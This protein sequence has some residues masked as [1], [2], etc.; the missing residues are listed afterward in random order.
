[1]K[2]L[3]INI[4]SIKKYKY[5][6]LELE[7]CDGFDIP[8][9]FI[10]DIS[11]PSI[12]EKGDLED[13]YYDAYHCYD[14]FI[15]L[16]PA[17]QELFSRFSKTKYED[18]TF[19]YEQEDYDENEYKFFNRISKYLDICSISLIDEKDK[20]ITIHIPYDPV[21][22]PDDEV[23]EFSNCHSIELDENNDVII[24]VGKSSNNPM[25]KRKDIS[26]LIK[27][28]NDY[29]ERSNSFGLEINLL[30]IEMTMGDKK[31]ILATLDIKN[32]EIKKKN[33]K[34]LFKNCLGIE[35]NE[36]DYTY[37]LYIYRLLDGKL[38]VVFE[39]Q[40]CFFCDGCYFVG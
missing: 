19:E 35:F 24:K 2:Q 37:D 11:L 14:G 27:N 26:K 8:I 30:K 39:Y 6:H 5:I 22:T 23:I 29:F 16:S 12:K 13:K 33:V 34:I 38:Y 17:V 7:N 3:I 40:I 32:K 20:W 31:N 28:W 21:V 25:I 4:D 10:L 1:M 9:D 15:K 18:G 36:Y